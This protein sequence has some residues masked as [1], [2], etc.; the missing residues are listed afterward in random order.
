MGWALRIGHVGSRSL[1]SVAQLSSTWDL[2]AF[3]RKAF[4]PARPAKLPL[5]G[6]H[7]P[8]ACSKWFVS[9]DSDGLAL[10]PL[11]W[12]KFKDATVTTSSRSFHRSEAPL[13]IL[14]AYLSQ[15]QSE[16]GKRGSRSGVSVYLAQCSLGSLPE[17]LQDDLPT[18]EMVL[19][20]GKGDVY[21]S[22]LWL[23]DASS[24][25]PLHRDPNP[26]LFMQ[27]AGRKELRL[28]PPEAGD[29]L[30]EAIQESLWQQGR[31]ISPGSAAFRGEKMMTGPEADLLHE[32][33]WQEGTRASELMQAY[34]Q[35]VEVSGQEALFIPKHWWHS[36][37]GVGRGV[38]ASVNWWFR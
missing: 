11:F 25:T 27:L 19:R 7:I 3:R 24:Y 38:T 20:A 29:A 13:A 16:L 33:V 15:Q 35:R 30:F 21:E 36:V 5:G 31:L 12:S 18:P 10:D 32:A 14:L 8:P 1:S 26:N 34:G 22:S 9:N 37:K 23:G 2:D 17:E 6:E 4:E 28:L